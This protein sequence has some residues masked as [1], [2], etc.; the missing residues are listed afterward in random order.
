MEEKIAAVVL[1]RKSV[2]GCTGF[3]LRF[4]NIAFTSETFLIIV[5]NQESERLG[6]DKGRGRGAGGRIMEVLNGCESRRKRE[7]TRGG[8]GNEKTSRGK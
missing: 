7:E 1:V 8:R 5:R 2:S 6:D 3:E 4:Y